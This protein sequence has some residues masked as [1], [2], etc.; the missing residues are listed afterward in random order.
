MEIISFEQLQRICAPK[1]PA[2]RASTVRRWAERQGIRY[3]SD[4]AGGIWTT[5]EALNRALG[6]PT[7]SDGSQTNMHVEDLV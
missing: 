2:P 7:A 1:G 5:Q 4:G 3:R 6:L